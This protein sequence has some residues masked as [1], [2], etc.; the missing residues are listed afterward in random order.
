MMIA[1][2]SPISHNS[3]VPNVLALMTL[4]HPAPDV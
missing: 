1:T 2:A 4:L 3:T